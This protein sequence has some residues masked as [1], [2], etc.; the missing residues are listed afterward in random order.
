MN[1]RATLG[2]LLGKSLQP[3]VAGVLPAAGSSAGLEPFTGPWTRA[4]AAHLLRR[5]MFGPTRADMDWAANQDLNTVLNTLLEDRPLPEPPL[6]YEEEDDPNVPLGETWVNAPLVNFKNLRPSR[7]RSLEAWTMGVMIQEGINI[8]EKMTL[9]WQ[10]HFAVID[11]DVRD[12]R[13][14]YNYFTLLRSNALANFRE[15]VKQLTIAPSMLR[16]LNG[17]QNTKKAPNENYARELL[18]LY[19]VG[20]GPQVAPGDYTHFTEQDV[21][22]ISRILTGWKDRGWR[23]TNPDQ[24]IT[25]FFQDDEH[26]TGDKQLSYRF[27]DV[28]ISNMGE[29][30]YAHLIDIIFQKP[31]AARHICRKLYRWFVYYVIDDQIEST[32]IEP[33]AQQLIDNDFEIKPVLQTLLSSA[34]FYDALNLGPMIKHPLDFVVSTVKQLEVTYPSPTDDL[35]SLYEGWMQLLRKAQRMNMDYFNPPEVA[36]WKAWY[37]APIYSRDWINLN[38]LL[39]RMDFTSEV[40]YTG[41]FSGDDF[42][43]KA[44]LLALIA[45]FDNPS[46]PNAMIRTFAD[47]LFPL[48]LTGEMD[49]TG[50]YISGQYKGLKEVLIPGLPDF[51][52]TVEYTDYLNNPDD[53]DIKQA[54]E[55]KLKQMVNIMLSLAEFHLS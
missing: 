26:D 29:Q 38:T 10:N 2:L 48:P 9:F 42:R 13:Y 17:N 34:H 31:A 45:T 54:V 24:E 16:F 1:R 52:W 11:D 21:L 15:L 35:N 33:L 12:E 49:D 14:S 36:G 40:L 25:S 5:C 19:T 28:V 51:E 30:E 47:L 55:D 18:E 37:Q 8:R 46:D 23:T 3:E 50:S 39:D 44:D 43:I 53:E 4:E 20:K 6:N 27:E 7:H 32:I 22:E 41:V